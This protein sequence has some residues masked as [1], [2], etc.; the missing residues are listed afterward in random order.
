MNFDLT[1][2]L[3]DTYCRRS[4]SFNMV[5]CMCAL[6][7]HLCCFWVIIPSKIFHLWMLVRSFI[8]GAIIH[9][10][11]WLTANKNYPLTY[12]GSC[13]WCH[14]SAVIDCPLEGSHHWKF[15][16][17]LLYQL[18]IDK[19]RY[20]GLNVLIMSSLW[21]F[22]LWYVYKHP[23]KTCNTLTYIKKNYIATVSMTTLEF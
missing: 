21:L 15:S 9:S 10:W 23:A 8:S 22:I 5:V 20:S 13:N 2:Y 19:K 6:C 17:F 16:I 12:L 7:L 18:H 11:Q 3:A 1:Y 4:I 14:N